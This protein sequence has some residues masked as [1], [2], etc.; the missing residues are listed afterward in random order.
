MI[1]IG[2]WAVCLAFCLWAYWPEGIGSA[3]AI[4]GPVGPLLYV[5]GMTARVT[6]T[7]SAV[8]VDNIFVR[9]RIARSL[10]VPPVPDGSFLRL[11]GNRLADITA[12]SSA[13]ERSTDGFGVRWMRTALAE[14]PPLPDDGVRSL[15]PRVSNI[16]IVTAALAVWFQEWHPS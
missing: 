6:V 10:L 14:I 3:L 16:V 15:R 13:L 12:L 5:W 2:I 8:I 7:A 1:V 4:I 11:P 9:R